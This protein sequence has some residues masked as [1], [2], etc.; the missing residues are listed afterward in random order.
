MSERT[1]WIVRVTYNKHLWQDNG[2][3]D[4]FKV[5]TITSDTRC[6][7]MNAAKHG[8]LD[9]CVG[10]DSRGERESSPGGS[11]NLP[12][13]KIEYVRVVTMEE[14]VSVFEADDNA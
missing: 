10:I 13:K 2:E 3:G 6:A 12:I 9:E 1:E 14:S 8:A 5:K 4:V 7:N 11:S